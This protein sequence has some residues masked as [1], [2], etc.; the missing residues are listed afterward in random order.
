[1]LLWL[2]VTRLLHVIVRLGFVTF[3]GFGLGGHVVVGLEVGVL[4]A[5]GCWFV[6]V[7][8]KCRSTSISRLP[9]EEIV[10]PTPTIVV[11]CHC[12]VPAD[13]V[14][15]GA[16]IASVTV[17]RL[18][19]TSHRLVH[20]SI[21]MQPCHLVPV[22]GFATG[23]C[24]SELVSKGGTTTPTSER[25]IPI[26]VIQVFYIL[27]HLILS[28]PNLLILLICHLLFEFLC[29]CALPVLLILLAVVVAALEGRGHYVL[30][31]SL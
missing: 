25:I 2:L 5:S 13:W 9:P 21:Q 4:D 19:P 6:K 11:V 10:I 28:I 31:C 1:M 16:T 26:I 20:A 8:T 3:L 27:N 15:I 7:N 12:W 18:D 14:G 24:V 23:D 22:L 30:A 29:I 17:S